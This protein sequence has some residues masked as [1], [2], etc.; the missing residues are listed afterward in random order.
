MKYLKLIALTSLFTVTFGCSTNDQENTNNLNGFSSTDNC[1]QL[2][3]GPTSAYWEYGKGNPLPLSEQP[4][5]QNPQATFSYAHSNTALP[6]FTLTPPQGYTAV[7][8]AN[9]NTNPFG[10]NIIRNDGAAVWR[11]VPISTYPANFT[12][13]NIL[14][15]EVNNVTNAFGFNGNYNILCE[16]EPIVF[17]ENG[18]LRVFRSRMIEFNN[19]RALVVIAAV[20][21]E[22]LFTASVLHVVA[23][24]PS[25]EYNNLVMNIFLPLHYQLNPKGESPLSDRDNDGVEDIFDS[26]P[27]DPNVQ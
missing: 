4:V 19:T 18:V 9:P 1:P 15:I 25:E 14:D 20:Y 2:P 8:Y 10:V 6:P 5:L 3:V 22:S 24:G 26:A 11:Y 21:L 7:D 23:A 16:S 27:D 13:T 12:S 17:S